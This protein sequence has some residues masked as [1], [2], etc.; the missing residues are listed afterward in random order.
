MLS[1]SIA[2][3]Y[4]LKISVEIPPE[5]KTLQWKVF[6]FFP[7]KLAQHSDSMSSALFYRNLL[8]QQKLVKLEA[9]THQGLEHDLLVL[10]QTAYAMAKVNKSLYRSALADLVAASL[11]MLTEMSGDELLEF[12]TYLDKFHQIHD[13]E[14]RLTQR[15]LFKLADHL[16]LYHYHQALLQAKHGTTKEERG[17]YSLRLKTLTAYAERENLRLSHDTEFGREKLLDRL[18]L[19]QRIINR[20]YQLRRKMLNSNVLAEQLIFGFA[21]AFAMAFATAVA[22]ITQRAFGNFSTPFFFSLVLSYIFKDRI[23]ELGRNYLMEKYFAHYFQHHYRFYKGS[24][25]EVLFDA[26]ETLY[27]LKSHHFQGLL[28]RVRKAFSSSDSGAFKE[29]LVYQRGYSVNVK[30]RQSINSKFVDDLTLNFSGRLRSL[31]RVIRRHWREA[32]RSIQAVNVEQVHPI[33]LAFEIKTDAETSHKIYKLTASRK[34]I[35]GL[36]E[37]IE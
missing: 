2:D 3:Q 14:D 33:Y 28:K 11:E 5:L 15:K 9:V 13:D 31:P 23:K 19:A 24:E 37:A 6:L 30:K 8:Q 27:R 12:A 22:F 20:P 36:V 18:Q 29:A 1:L 17:Q 32:D 25:S 35:H 10:R 34:G 4:H 7:A 21:A 26:K 16:L